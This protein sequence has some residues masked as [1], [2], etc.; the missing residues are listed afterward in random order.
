[1]VELETAAQVGALLQL[2]WLNPL[3]LEG[4]NRQPK[5][6]YKLILIFD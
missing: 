4:L 5:L 1:L 6:T 3:G 2:L